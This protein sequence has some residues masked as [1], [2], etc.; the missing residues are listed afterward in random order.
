MVRWAPLAILVLED[1]LGSRDK[2]IQEDKS[3]HAN[4]DHNFIPALLGLGVNQVYLGK[5]VNRVLMEPLEILVILE[6]QAFQDEL[7]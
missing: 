3:I 1:N 2:G 7:D 5:Q 4:N 6:Y